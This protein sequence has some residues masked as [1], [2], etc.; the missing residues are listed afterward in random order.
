M[1]FNSLQFLIFFPLVVLAYFLLPHRFRWAFLL[2]ASYYFYMCWK[3]E[4]GLLL[5]VSTMAGYW[6]A[7]RIG[8][9]PKGDTH[10]KTYLTLSL[11]ANI[12]ILFAFKYFNFFNDSFRALFNHFNIFYGVPAFNVLL[13]VGIS[14]Y[15]FQT[16][17]YTIDVYRGHQRPETHLGKFALYVSFFPQLVAGP[18]ERAARLLPQFSAT[19][20]FDY[21]RMCSGLRLMLWGFFKKLVIADRLALFVDAVFDDPS[22]WEGISFI[23]AASLFGWQI[24]CDFSGYSD[25]AVGSAR[26]LG[27]DLMRNFNR[28]FI[29]RSITE[30]WQRWHISLSTW[31]RDYL[32]LPLCGRSTN[33]RWWVFSIFIVFMISGLWHGAA[34]TF[35][36]CGAL[37]AAY[38]IFEYLSFNSRR[39]WCE[40]TG[41]KNHP[42]THRALNISITMFM[43]FFGWIF[44]RANSIQDAV[45]VLQ[46]LSDG[47][48]QWFSD[49]IH[50]RQ[51][52]LAP[53]VAGN[54]LWELLIGIAAIIIMET[55]QMVDDQLDISQVL[56]RRP[57]WFRWL[58]YYGLVM[59]ILVFGRFEVM[60]FIYFQF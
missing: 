45:Y 58:I 10:R 27:F 2:V 32:Y 43:L 28:P 50:L 37:H 34:W 60:E 5:L 44:F 22:K 46:H 55:V 36:A 30:F 49:V 23:A 52:A 53:V 18:I 56:A 54:T 40:R 3:V 16:M 8:T 19:H 31:L 47:L 1:L 11:G 42:R 24:Y 21:D 57:V 38:L 15:T 7:M 13:P 12:A 48:P 29:S 6:G 35:I 33:K 20:R 14:F 59:I 51:S 25:I 26:V 41:L 39:K 9:L 4:Y 17:S